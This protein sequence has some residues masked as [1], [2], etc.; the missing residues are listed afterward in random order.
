MKSR[1]LQRALKL[2]RILTQ[3]R[4]GFRLLDRQMRG[5]LTLAIDVETDVDAAEI[6]GVEP[7]FEAA[8]ACSCAVTAI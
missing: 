4:Q 8:L 2:R 7:D 3:H 6:G 1:V 5:D